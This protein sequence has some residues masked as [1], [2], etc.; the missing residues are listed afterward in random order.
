VRSQMPW[1]RLSAL[2]IEV[3]PITG[4]SAQHTLAGA[5][6]SSSVTAR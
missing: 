3:G 4:F 5:V 1:V 6:L 2:L